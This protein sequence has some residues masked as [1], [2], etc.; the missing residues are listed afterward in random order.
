M[1]AFIDKEFPIEIGLRSSGGPER[2]THVEIAG[3]GREERNQQWAN[4]RRRYNV[5]TGI[6]NASEMQEVAHFFEEMRGRLTGFLFCDPLDFKSCAIAAKVSASDQIIGFGDGAKTIF[7]LVKVYGTHQPYE[8]AIKKPKA[9]S[10]LVAVDGVTLDVSAYSVDAA[11]GLVTLNQPPE[12]GQS[13]TAGF[14]FYVP[15]RFDVDQLSLSWD[16]PNLASLPS[17]P[18]VEVML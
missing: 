3:S 12:A 14:W 1:Q 9:S 4:S 8:R 18:I 16:G 2:R 17:I 15:V 13:V 7:Q 10:V 11:T 6:R 5:G